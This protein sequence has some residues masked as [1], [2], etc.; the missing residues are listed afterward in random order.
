MT[1]HTRLSTWVIVVSILITAFSA[2]PSWPSV[3]THAL[4][5][6]ILAFAL[7]LAHWEGRN[8]GRKEGR[9]Q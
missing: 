1:I 4:N 2:F 6:P 7:W 9:E 8:E 5:V 3:I